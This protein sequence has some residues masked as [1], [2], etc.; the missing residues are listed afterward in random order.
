VRRGAVGARP[1]VHICIHIIVSMKEALQD[2]ARK[3][4]PVLKE[5]LQ[6]GSIARPCMK[7]ALQD[8]ALT[9]QELQYIARPCTCKTLH[10]H[11]R[12]IARPCTYITGVAV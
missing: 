3:V 8:L 6:E 1:G 12:S 2:L 4:L 10:L 7:E 9:S 11:H 5:A